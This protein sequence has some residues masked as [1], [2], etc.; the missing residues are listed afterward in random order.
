[1]AGGP[2]GGA[3]EQTW[4]SILLFADLVESQCRESLASFYSTNTFTL[5]A[6]PAASITVSVE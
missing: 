4:V 2:E 3:S 6:R 5:A 1:M